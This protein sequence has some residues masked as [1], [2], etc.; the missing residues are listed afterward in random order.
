MGGA[1]DLAGVGDE[2]V[3]A[4][5]V[6]PDGAEEVG[7]RGVGRDV[8]GEEDGGGVDG[9]GDGGAE[10]GAS[11]GEGD[12]VAEGVEVVGELGANAALGRVLVWGW[13]VRGEGK[14]D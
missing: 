12:A 3:E 14:G 4:A 2:D 6:R 10:V 9:G 8:G 13:F 1:V 7:L 5:K 11:A